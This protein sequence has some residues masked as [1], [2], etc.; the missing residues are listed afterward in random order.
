MSSTDPQAS[1]AAAKAAALSKAEYLKRYM[2]PSSQTADTKV[3]KKKRRFTGTDNMKVMP[4]KVE[5]VRIHDDSLAVPDA[6]PE[7]PDSEEDEEGSVLTLRYG[8]LRM[9]R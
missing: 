7:N 1:V 6:A 8:F 3:K 4:K 2:E 9:R 5:N